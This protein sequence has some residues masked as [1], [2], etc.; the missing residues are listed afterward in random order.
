MLDDYIIE[1]DESDQRRVI[2]TVPALHLIVLG[3]TLDEARALASA[4]ISFRAQGT[5]P[6]SRK[7][8]GTEDTPDDA[9]AA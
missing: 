1:T 8:T 7:A 4:A 3:Q 2:L 9:Q 6:P 5:D